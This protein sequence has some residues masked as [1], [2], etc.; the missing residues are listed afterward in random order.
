MDEGD[1]GLAAWAGNHAT[2]AY[3]LQAPRTASRGFG[4]TPKR[5]AGSAALD[6][7]MDSLPCEAKPASGIGLADDAGSRVGE[8][9]GAATHSPP[10]R[11]RE[12]G[13][14]VLDG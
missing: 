8:D 9:G 2:S 11:M 3:N 4:A 7:L 1:L 14:I 12:T 13:S 6:R 5:Y 10:R